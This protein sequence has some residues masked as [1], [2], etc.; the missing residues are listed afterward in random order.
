MH[1]RNRAEHAAKSRDATFAAALSKKVANYT[2]LVSAI[3]SRR[4]K[5]DLTKETLALTGTLLSINPDYA[6][7]WNY[8]RDIIEDEGDVGTWDKESE[9][10]ED[11]E[12]PSTSTHC[13]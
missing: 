6:T 11:I 4:A 9:V 8:R 1:G 10:R 5:G 2:A 13:P 7:L 3:S 12:L